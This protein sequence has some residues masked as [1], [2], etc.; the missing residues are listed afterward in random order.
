MMLAR[1]PTRVDLYERYQAIVQEYNQDKDAA[2]IQ[3]VM[4]KLFATWD[5]L[6]VEERRYIREG[7][8]SE[9]QLA[10]FDL[11]QKDTLSK[12]DRDAI[13]KVAVEL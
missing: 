5:T 2:E 11:L 10:V 12:G 3:K 8:D 4:D 7:L 6:D 9:D 1:N 13:K